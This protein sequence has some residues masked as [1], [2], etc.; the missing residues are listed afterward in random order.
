M[1]Y[2][3]QAN[4]QFEGVL[5]SFANGKYGYFKIDI[6]GNLTGIINEDGDLI[7]IKIELGTLFSVYKEPTATEVQNVHL[8]FMV[9]ESV[10]DADL[11][12]LDAQTITTDLL[13]ISGL[14]DVTGVA[15]SP[16]TTGFMY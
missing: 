7:P 3:A 8:K 4:P 1:V 6:N 13:E 5:N 2:G 14:I 15:T 12:T 16:S 11:R 10:K 9:K